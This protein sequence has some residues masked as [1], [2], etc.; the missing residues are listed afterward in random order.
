MYFTTLMTEIGRV[1]IAFDLAGC[2]LLK[3]KNGLAF[4]LRNC[5]G[6]LLCIWLK[7]NLTTRLLLCYRESVTIKRKRQ[8]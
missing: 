2:L 4:G 3:W 5:Y 6:L 8:I 7:K 1:D